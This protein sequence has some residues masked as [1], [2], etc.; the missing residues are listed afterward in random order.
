MDV[1]VAT[2]A[3]T[4]PVDDKLS[5]NILI[6]GDTHG[7]FSRF[8]N[9]KVRNA[10]RGMYPSHIIILGDFGL[11][12]DMNPQNP[13]EAYNIKWFNEKPWITLATLGNH[14]NYER[15]YQL[16]LVDLYGGKAYK[17]SDKIYILQHGHVFTIEGKTFFNFGGGLSIDKANRRNRISWWEEEIP[18]QAD[19][20]R[21]EESLKAVGSRVDYVITHTAPQEAINVFKHKLPFGHSS[22]EDDEYFNLKYADPTV[23]MLS[24]LLKQIRFEK[25][26][27]GHFHLEIPFE[28]EGRQYEL[29][30]ENLKLL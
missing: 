25:W 13:T 8:A 6:S 5:H 29:M 21:A 10:C 12:W 4:E 20:Y 16:P 3:N 30:Y 9:Q 15:I 14:E 11:I 27:F 24:A 17:V 1:N 28:A 18:V 2:P 23:K 22:S 26:F 19:F 7:D